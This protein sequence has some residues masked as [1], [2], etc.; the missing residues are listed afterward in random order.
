MKVRSRVSA[1]GIRWFVGNIVS[2]YRVYS[3]QVVNSCGCS[4]SKRREEK[5]QDEK[6]GRKKERNNMAPAV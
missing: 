4:A 2:A 1:C 6:R 3:W 5:L